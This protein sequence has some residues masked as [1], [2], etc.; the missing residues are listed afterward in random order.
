MLWKRIVHQVISA[1]IVWL[2]IMVLAESIHAQSSED[3]S[4][5]NGISEAWRFDTQALSKEEIAMAKARWVE[6]E[7]KANDEWAGD[8]ES[9][10]G[11]HETY[12]RWATQKGFVMM[13]V[14]LCEARVIDVNYGETTSSPA[15]IQFHPKL[16]KNRAYFDRAFLPVKWRG[17]HYL[18]PENQIAGFGDYV[19]GLGAYNDGLSQATIESGDFFYKTTDRGEESSD[20][21]PVVPTGYERFIKKP[22][23]AIITTVGRPYI[24]VDLENEGWNDSITPVTI[25]AGRTD[26]VKRRMTLFVLGS[27]NY[28]VVEIRRVELNSAQ[29]VL[30]RQVRKNPGTKIDEW[31]DGKPLEYP[32]IEV[33]WMLST[34]RI[35]QQ[36]SFP[37][38]KSAAPGGAIFNPTAL[39]HALSANIH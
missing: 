35:K 13:D 31:D 27:G 12:I 18:I 16:I 38:E 34:S 6:L 4:W 30:V 26:G 32:K 17:V 39:R 22:I 7:E 36:M 20:E 19:A 33:G 15:S 37:G 8:Y 23:A 2:S 29:G 14:N 10:N 3:D 9:G 24:K 25:N 21:L 11:V 5:Q 28:E 1:F